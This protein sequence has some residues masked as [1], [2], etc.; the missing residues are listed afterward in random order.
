MY[1]SPRKTI[2]RWVSV[3]LVGLGP[4]DLNALEY[5]PCFAFSLLLKV[6]KWC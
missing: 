5:V 3:V 1:V 4:E 2:D 6:R